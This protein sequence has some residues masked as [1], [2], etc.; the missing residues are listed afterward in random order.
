MVD[1]WSNDGGLMTRAENILAFVHWLNQEQDRIRVEIRHGRAP[2]LFA[3]E[4]VEASLLVE[5]D[6][7]FFRMRGGLEA[8]GEHVP[9]GDVLEAI[10]HARAYV[11]LPSGSYIEIPVAMQ[12]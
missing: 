10:R 1:T 12:D 5:K 9:F 4:E 11:R 3:I 8:A 2:R 7:G 6:R